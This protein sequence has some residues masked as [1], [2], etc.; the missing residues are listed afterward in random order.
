MQKNNNVYIFF[1]KSNMMK[2]NGKSFSPQDKMSARRKSCSIKYK[3]GIMEESM[4][5]NLV[6]C[7]ENNLNF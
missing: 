4:G 6:S 5:K 7:K 3:K 1:Q 2:L